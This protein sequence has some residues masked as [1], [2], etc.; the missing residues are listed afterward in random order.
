MLTQYAGPPALTQLTDDE[1]LFQDSVRKFA[2]DRIAP[3]SA[4]MDVSQ[5]MDATLIREL[6]ALVLMGIP[7]PDDLGGAGCSFFDS[8]LAVEAISA[9][10]PAVGVLVDVQNTLVESALLRWGTDAQQQHWLPK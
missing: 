1:R 7:I 9:A 10:D 4:S 2:A 3:L 8:V 6:F 5:Q